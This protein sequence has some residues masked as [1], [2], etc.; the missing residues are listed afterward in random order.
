M[1]KILFSLLLL[2]ALVLAETPQNQG[3]VIVDK[4]VACDRVEVVVSWLTEY[5]RQKPMWVGSTEGDSA[6]AIITNEKTGTWTVIEF[7]QEYACI[8]S[9]GLKNILTSP[10]Y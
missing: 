7:N 5:E 9:T 4:S 3:P 1:K 2:P 6:V 8:L 10:L